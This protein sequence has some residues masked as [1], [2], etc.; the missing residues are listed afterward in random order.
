ML[1]TKKKLINVRVSVTKEKLTDV[2]VSVPDKGK[3]DTRVNVSGTEADTPR[4]VERSRLIRL[5]GNSAQHTLPIFTT[6]HH[7]W[8]LPK[9]PEKNQDMLVCFCFVS[10]IIFLHL[11]LCNNFIFHATVAVTTGPLATNIYM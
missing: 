2:R 1:Q 10:L 5:M 9:L 7:A 11:P 8:P 6:F 4:G 3:G